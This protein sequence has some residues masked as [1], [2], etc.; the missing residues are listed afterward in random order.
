MV[1]FIGLPIIIYFKENVFWPSLQVC[2]LFLQK[3]AINEMC[4]MH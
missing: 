2:R 3:T 1:R 4:Q